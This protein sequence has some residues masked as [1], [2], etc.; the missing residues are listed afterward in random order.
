MPLKKPRK[1]ASSKTKA[2]I[3]SQNIKELVNSGYP[4]K[5]AV[6]IAYSNEKKKK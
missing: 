3:R 4:T 5:Q 2:K 6:A 1:N